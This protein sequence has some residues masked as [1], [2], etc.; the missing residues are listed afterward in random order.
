MV[1]QKHDTPT[2]LKELGKQLGYK[3]IVLRFADDKTL[4]SNL[5]TSQGN[6]SP[7]AL[8]N[9]IAQLVNVAIDKRLLEHDGPVLVHPLTNEASVSVHVKDMVKCIEVSGHAWEEVEF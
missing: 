7:L 6:V 4:A 5:G 2:N 3:N 1:L 8:F 9:D